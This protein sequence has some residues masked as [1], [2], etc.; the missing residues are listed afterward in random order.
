MVNDE[1]LE[2]VLEISSTGSQTIT[3][4]SSPGVLTRSRT[5]ATLTPGGDLMVVT[6]GSTTV[7]CG[8]EFIFYCH[9]AQN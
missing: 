2:A 6:H 9:T 1:E 3:V 5:S 4:F 7:Q 8:Q